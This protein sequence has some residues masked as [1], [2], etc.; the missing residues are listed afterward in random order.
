MVLILTVPFELNSWIMR[1]CQ[2]RVNQYRMLYCMTW[3]NRSSSH[4]SP[5]EN[6]L[7]AEVP[8][9]RKGC[10]YTGLGFLYTFKLLRSQ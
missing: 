5:Y 8:V 7:Q 2:Q 4:C 1:M 3:V 6:V 9:F 10:E